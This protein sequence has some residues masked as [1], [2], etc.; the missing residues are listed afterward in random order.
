[1]MFSDYYV[2]IQ[3]TYMRKFFLIFLLG[4]AALLSYA[5]EAVSDEPI[6]KSPLTFNASVLFGMSTI[7]NH[8]MSSNSYDGVVYGVHVDF[9]RFYRS[10]EN[11]SWKLA[12]DKYSSA[13]PATGL[14]NS[15][16]T[17]SMGYSAMSL[18][19]GSFYNWK[20]GE[21]LM[22]KVGGGLDI[23]GDM[24]SN[25]THSTNNAASMNVLAQLE[26]SAGIS[27]TFKFEKWMLALGGN[28]STPFAG[29]IMTDAKHESGLGSFASGGFVGNYFSHVKGTTFSNLQ[30][31]D[32][33][34]GLKFI[35]K[36]VAINVELVSNNRSWYVNEI[37]NNRTDIMLRLGAT[38]NLVSLRQTKNISR[39]F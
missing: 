31:F 19:Y 3:V 15:A 35:A 14:E 39:Y 26:A 2:N 34:L 36:R 23:S 16:L 5:Q 25:L 32:F 7:S 38:F 27:Y 37:Q 11:V 33:D 29:V 17:S 21:G 9:G 4:S 24:I 30:G 8:Y 6:G 10:A 13:N 12:F 1:M 22:V 20:F 18:N 28:I